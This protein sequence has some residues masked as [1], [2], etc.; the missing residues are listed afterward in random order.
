MC[1]LNSL[2]SKNLVTNLFL[3]REIKDSVG[4]VSIL[5]LCPESFN[6]R[7]VFNNE[8]NVRLLMFHQNKVS[9]LEYS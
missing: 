8:W 7:N 3:A 6:Q 4:K 2:F 9:R 1:T 5:T